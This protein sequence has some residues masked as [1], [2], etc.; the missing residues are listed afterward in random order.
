VPLGFAHCA[1][2]RA[3][4]TT[5]RIPAGL[6]CTC[7]AISSYDNM[8]AWQG[9]SPGPGVHPRPSCDNRKY[10][11]Y[12]SERQHPRSQLMTA[13]AASVIRIREPKRPLA[14]WRLTVHVGAN[15][16][17]A[18]K[19]TYLIQASFLPKWPIVLGCSNRFDEISHTIGY[20]LMQASRN[21]PA[22]SIPLSRIHQDI[23]YAASQ[24]FLACI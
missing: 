9:T 18:S 12:V 11:N 22:M 17:A 15:G 20:A 8:R 10:T 1:W 24:P 14:W 3:D 21:A 6:F 5:C 19:A 4:Q 23:D 16:K 7:R 2:R 13:G